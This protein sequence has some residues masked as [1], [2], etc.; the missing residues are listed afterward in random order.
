MTGALL[1]PAAYDVAWSLVAL[2]QVVLVLAALV[3]WFRARATGEAGLLELVAVVVVP[4]LG[5]LA[6]LLAR[7]GAARTRAAG[8][9]GGGTGRGGDPAAG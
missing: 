7:R 6:Y 9:R 8:R 1:L 5:P 2:A 4:V 3:Q